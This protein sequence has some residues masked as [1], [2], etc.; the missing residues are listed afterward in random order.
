MSQPGQEEDIL[1][2]GEDELQDVKAQ[3]SLLNHSDNLKGSIEVREVNLGVG[4]ST[5]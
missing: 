1:L 2:M 4:D 3:N 5:D